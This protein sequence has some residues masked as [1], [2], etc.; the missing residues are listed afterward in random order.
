MRMPSPR[1][2]IGL[3][4]VLA[5]SVGTAYFLTKPEE[6]KPAE[7]ITVACVGG[8]EKSELMADESVRRILKEKFGI[9][10]TFSPLGSYDQV[11]LP[12]MSCETQTQLPVARQR[13]R[14]ERF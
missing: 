2:L 1:F 13:Q 8:S 4:L 5:V 12:P 11:Q 3:G 14:P 9:T 6:A 10:V 7:P